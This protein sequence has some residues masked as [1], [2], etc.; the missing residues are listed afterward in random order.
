MKF[1]FETKNINKRLY[2]IAIMFYVHQAVG[3]NKDWKKYKHVTATIRPMSMTSEDRYF[4]K[5]GIAGYFGNTE[6]VL[7]VVDVAGDWSFYTNMMMISIE[8]GHMVLY[9]KDRRERVQL[10]HNDEGGNVAGTK[11]PFYVAEVHDRHHEKKFY[12]MRFLFWDWKKIFFV[13]RIVARVVDIR[14]IA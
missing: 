2:R 12:T 3:S 11:L 7:Y 4:I 14:D 5:D 9:F 13:R 10:R 6:L 1:K 8:A